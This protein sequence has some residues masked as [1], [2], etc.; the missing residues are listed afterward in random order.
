MAGTNRL[1][2][3]QLT[4][5]DACGPALIE[6]AAVS[7][8]DAVGLR[9][10]SPAGVAPHPPIAG[11]ETLLREVEASLAATGLTVLD[12]NSFWITPDITVEHFKPVIDAAVRLR[13]PHVLVVI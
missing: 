5:N 10:V 13:A 7:G 11:N 8:F 4:I 12:V 6:A 3:A 2:L 1:S 9:V